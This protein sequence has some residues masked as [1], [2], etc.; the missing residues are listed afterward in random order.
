MSCANKK[1]HNPTETPIF[2]PAVREGSE[3]S[4]LGAQHPPIVQ[5]SFEK[6]EKNR[7]FLRRKTS[8]IRS[9]S[10][11]YYKSREEMSELVIFFNY[12]MFRF[13]N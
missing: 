10:S 11:V 4:R 5:Q 3:Q 6:F 7:V 13:V 1:E 8:K 2:C 12:I 9:L